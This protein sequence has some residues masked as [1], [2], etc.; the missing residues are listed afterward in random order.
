MAVDAKARVAQLT[1]FRSITAA[2][3]LPAA[4]GCF[5]SW[6]KARLCAWW[7]SSAARMDGGNGTGLVFRRGRSQTGPREGQAPPL[8]VLRKPFGGWVGEPLG[9]PVGGVRA[10]KTAVG[11]RSA[12]PSGSHLPW[13]AVRLFRRGRSQTGPTGYRTGSVCSANPGAEVEP[14][15]RQF[16]Q[17]QGPVARKES[18]KATQIL[19]AGNIAR[20][21]RY[22]SPVMGSGGKANYG[23]GGAKRADPRRV[24]GGVLVTLPPWAKSLAVRRR[25]NLLRK[26]QRTLER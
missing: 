13:K 20:P 24:P 26:T 17:T 1:G 22:A 2:A 16:L 11:L 25:R 4:F 14:H 9:A 5:S 3:E 7:G 23:A 6:L 15:R 12:A 19:R 10:H 21:D 18:R 8:R